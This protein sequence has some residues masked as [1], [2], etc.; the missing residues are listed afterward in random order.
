MIPLPIPE[1]HQ[2]P[3]EHFIPAR[4]NV[5]MDIIAR[6]ERNMH[7]ANCANGET[8]YAPPPVAEDLKALRKAA[9]ETVHKFI[10]GDIT[11]VIDGAPPRNDDPPPPVRQPQPARG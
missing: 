10:L 8:P 7:M 11:C 3:R 6:T 4:I 9:I 1:A 2:I 5:A